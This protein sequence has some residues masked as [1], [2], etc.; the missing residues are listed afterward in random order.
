MLLFWGLFSLQM[1]W[2]LAVLQGIIRL[3][4]ESGIKFDREALCILLTG[5][6]TG[7]GYIACC[8]SE[9]PEAIGIGYLVL[10][11]YLTICVVTDRQTCMVYDFLQLPAAA[12][13]AVMAL[14]CPLPPE[15]GAGLIIFALLQYLIFMRMYGKGD[16]MAFQICG[17]YIVSGG[18]SF[19]ILLLH[20]A[21]AFGLLGIVQLFRGNLNKRG[22]LIVPVPFLPYI[23]CTVLWFL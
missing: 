15:C 6:G 12:A 5:S 3:D 8:H 20:M 10:S 4:P 21:L 22:N 7:A 13:G 16:G 9:G 11:V 23:A 19:E 14:L 18:G 17:L 1:T 2:M